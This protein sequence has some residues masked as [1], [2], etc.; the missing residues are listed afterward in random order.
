MEYAEGLDVSARPGD[1]GAR[2]WIGYQFPTAV[3]MAE[4]LFQEGLQDGNGGAFVD[5]EVD[6]RSDLYALGVLTFRMLAGHEPFRG[7][8]HVV[9]CRGAI[10]NRHKGSSHSN[11]ACPGWPRISSRN[12]PS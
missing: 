7:E 9:G 5:L 4:L 1:Q 10:G 6:T 8:S 11:S 2:D 3:P 12:P